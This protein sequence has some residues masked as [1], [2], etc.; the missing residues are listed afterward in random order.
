M[1]TGVKDVTI[2]ATDVV[3]Q[4]IE[5]LEKM[6]AEKGWPVKAE[7]MPSEALMFPDATFTHS[8]TNLGL[9][10][11]EGDVAVAKH[12]LRTVKDGGVVVMSIWDKPLPVQAVTAGLRVARPAGA[13]IPPAIKRGSFD[14]KDLRNVIEMAGFRSETIKFERTYAVLE[15]K[16]LRLWA[17]AVWSF[18]GRPATG[19]TVEDEEKWDIVIDTMVNWMREY[20]GYKELDNGLV[21]FTMPAHVAITTK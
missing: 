15:V 8:L 17:S 12:I 16:D 18:L 10:V 3:P 20:E 9:M 1:K 4:V 14:D 21:T 7:V 11:M 13:E 2:F 6:A 19:W 5:Q